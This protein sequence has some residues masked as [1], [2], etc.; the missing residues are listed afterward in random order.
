MPSI[1]APGLALH[2]LD[3]TA[4]DGRPALT[5]DL[6]HRKAAAYLAL[7]PS[8]TAVLHAASRILAAFIANGTLDANNEQDLANRSVRLA[9]GM[10]VVI[11][12]YI[13]SDNEDW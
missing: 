10:A 1:A 11:E 6:R 7:Q 12:K 4:S 8:E 2:D 9:T 5:E 13:Q 3:K